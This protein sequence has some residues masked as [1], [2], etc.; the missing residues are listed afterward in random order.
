MR[1]DGTVIVRGGG[2]LATGTAWRMHRC[3]FRVAI[4]EKATPTFVRRSVAFGQAAFDGS[5]TVEGVTAQMIDSAADIL[6]VLD[7]VKIPVLVDPRGCS[8]S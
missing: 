6:R 3:G 4:L 8:I 1:S 2:D 7:G 5:T